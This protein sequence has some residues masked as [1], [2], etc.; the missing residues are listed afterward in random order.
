LK[1]SW[2][3]QI[4][5]LEDLNLHDNVIRTI[6][7]NVFSFVLGL[8]NLNMGKNGIK[9]ITQILSVLGPIRNSLK[10]LGLSFNSIELLDDF[11][12]LEKLVSLD[13][14]TNLIKT[15]NK[16]TFDHLKLLES[17]NL[18]SNQLNKIDDDS[19]ETLI[20]LKSLN[21]RN[22]YL[23]KLPN[24]S[25]LMNLT[26]L[27]FNNQ[28]GRLNA[29]NNYVFDVAAVFAGNG[30]RKNLEVNLNL[31][32]ITKIENKTFCSNNLMVSRVKS[33]IVSYTSFQKMEKC[34]L[35]Q[36][37]T[38]DAKIGSTIVEVSFLNEVITPNDFCNSSCAM[39]GFLEKYNVLLD[40]CYEMNICSNSSKLGFSDDCSNR[41]EFKCDYLG[42][43]SNSA[44]LNVRHGILNV[45][46][47]ISFI[48]TLN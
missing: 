8:A 29:L 6:D 42:G 34:V 40:P 32:N 27:D 33:I 23:S 4:T 31:N 24:L 12:F 45:A 30:Q 15:I 28:N 9:N 3:N 39:I 22:N 14:A 19:F 25:Y 46:L 16:T 7:L 43:N 36:L 5:K 17:V 38:L 13:L 10:M 1:A 11:S 35:K 20:N 26:S 47:I 2:F 21:L 18:E 48:L 37:G 41:A 44:S